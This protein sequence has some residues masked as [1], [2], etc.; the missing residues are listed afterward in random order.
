[1]FYHL[2]FACFHSYTLWNYPSPFCPP[3][4][5]KKEHFCWHPSTCRL[6]YGK[7]S[8]MRHR[9]PHCPLSGAQ[10]PYSLGFVPSIY[11]WYRISPQC[12]SNWSAL[13]KGF[14][15]MKLAIFISHYYHVNTTQT[16]C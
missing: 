14:E 4:S 2:S 3:A 7:T 12:P 13:E 8:A 6:Q 5:S 1:V 15:I 9:L 10:S 16:Q 11:G